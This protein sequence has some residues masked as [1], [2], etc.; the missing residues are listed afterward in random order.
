L[1]MTLLASGQAQKHITLNEALTR[2]DAL[3]MLSVKSRVLA[4]PPTSPVDGVRYI[5]GAAATGDWSGH[6]GEIAV[7]LNGGW[8]FAAPS[9]GWRAWVE[10]ESIDVFYFSGAWSAGATAPSG[11]GLQTLE[12]DHGITA[13]ASNLTTTQIGAGWLVFAV[14]AR[15]ISGIGGASAWGLGVDNAETRYASG[16]GVGL[17]ASANGV[18]GA[19]LAYL[20]AT[21][22]KLTAEGANFTSGSVRIAVH[23]LQIN[24]PGP[25]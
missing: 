23:Y 25:V 12:F 6:D 5:V 16:V 22:L 14:S 9:E 24:A 1:K 8:D 7:F 3:V 11:G 13:G 17:N 18:T 2:L 10:N 20:S 21:P 4:T 15:V 19:P